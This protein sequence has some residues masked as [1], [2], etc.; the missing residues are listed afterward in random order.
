M[1]YLALSRQQSVLFCSQ[2]KTAR[3][4]PFKCYASTTW[5]KIQ[6]KTAFLFFITFSPVLINNSQDVTHWMDTPLSSKFTDRANTRCQPKHNRTLPSE[7]LWPAQIEAVIN[8]SLLFFVIF[9][10]FNQL[11]LYINCFSFDLSAAT[12]PCME[13]YTTCLRHNQQS[14]HFALASSHLAVY[15]TGWRRIVSSQLISRNFTQ[16]VA[17]NNRRHVAKC[18][19]IMLD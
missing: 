13:V 19:R 2:N 16:S 1:E 12:R 14:S 3:Y 10:H 8:V 18:W 9:K 5:P 15:W 7:R 4:L 17:P 11:S 6:E